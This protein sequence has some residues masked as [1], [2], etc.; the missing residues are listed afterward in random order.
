M[1]NNATSLAVLGGDPSIGRALM[2]LLQGVGYDVRFLPHP[3]GGDLGKLL[4]SVHLVLLAPAL[5]PRARESLLSGVRRTPNHVTLPVV[6]LMPELDE[7]PPGDGMVTYIPWP[8]RTAEL[9][10]EIEALLSR[11]ESGAA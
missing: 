6:V 3:V 11:D 2:L 10:R 4:D 9:S 7:A 5:G 8:C 1:T